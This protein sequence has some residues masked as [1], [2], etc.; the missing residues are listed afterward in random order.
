MPRLVQ[1]CMLRLS[2]EE[3]VEVGPPWH[4]TFAFGRGAIGIVWRIKQAEGST[5]GGGRK[6]DRLDWREII[7]DTEVSAIENI[8]GFLQNPIAAR[9]EIKHDDA[10]RMRWRAGDKSGL[11][12]M[13]AQRRELREG[14]IERT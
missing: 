13:G 9:T 5:S 12:A 10:R 2:V 8:G 14:C 6:L 1:Y 7:A 3:A 11:I 4:L